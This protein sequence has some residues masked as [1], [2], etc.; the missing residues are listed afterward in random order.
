MKHW[1]KKRKGLA[2]AVALVLV[3]AIGAGLV[4]LAPGGGEVVGVYPFSRVGMTEYWGDS[5]ESY[6]PVSTD[7]IQTV[8]L[9]DTQ[10]VTEILVKAGDKVKKGDVLMT[11]D[12]T[13]SGLS[14]ERKRLEV[15]KQ[16][17]A[18]DIAQRELREIKIMEPMEIP[19]Y[20]Q[21]TVDPF[22]GEVRKEP[23]ELFR[24]EGNDGTTQEKAV[25]CWLR[26]DVDT[27]DI[28]LE[29]IRRKVWNNAGVC[30][31]DKLTED[32]EICT[33]PM[34][35]HDNVAA[36]CDICNVAVCEHG[37]IFKLCEICTPVICRHDEVEED[38]A[39]CN[40]ERCQ[41][42]NLKDQCN[43]CVP[44]CIHG[45]N[46]AVCFPKCAHGNDPDTCTTCHP[47]KCEHG[48]DPDTCKKCPCEHGVARK[49]C[50]T[51]NPPAETTK[52]EQKQKK[53]ESA[54]PADPAQS[55]EP[56]E[57]TAASVSA[58]P[59]YRVQLLGKPDKKPQ[60]VPENYDYYVVFKV[61]EGNYQLGATTTWQ[62]VHVS[63]KGTDFKLDFFDPAMEDYSIPEIEPDEPQ[64]TQPEFDM[65]SGY[66]FEQIVQL[67]KEKEKQIKKLEFDLKM[68]QTEYKI[69]QTEL[70]DGNVYA[71]IDGEVISV[72]TEEEAKQNRQPVLKVSGGG[73]FL[74]Q[75][76]VSELEKEKM[77]IGQEVTVNDWNS[78]Q[79]Y[80]GT[81]RSMGD[82]PDSNGYW[83]GM[84]N[85]NTTYYPF[86][87]FVDGTAD[88]Q[89]GSYVS[90]MYSGAGSEN[91][92]YLEN[93]FLR[94][95][96]GRSYVY[97]LGPGG[98]LERRDVVTGKSLW[99]S[100][101]EILSGLSETDLIAFPYGKHVKPGAP[102]E[103]RD[104][105]ELYS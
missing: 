48:K 49:D 58:A 14:L 11:F 71:D 3:A 39:L 98:K 65:G 53:S 93:P 72:L 36:E 84:G 38:C 99:G 79:T 22:L 37:R 85:P 9:T 46:C 64:P 5:Q 16:Q 61:T 35:K 68:V 50:T 28:L 21:T 92:I 45:E 43:I 10:T 44:T 90:L 95:E 15:E 18:L 57:D 102:A 94:T 77:E 88:L 33:P 7:N 100:Y 54:K 86:T 104:L 62:G 17:L 23:Y 78:G 103:E 41:H 69:M 81:I 40:A 34:C 4:F 82:F 87:V 66:T 59:G 101:T 32:C 26:E 56:R 51:C 19:Y 97:V 83:N 80:T 12:T 24:I 74:I 29:E 55:T 67:L 25:V 60:K 6:G 20:D 2:A 8:F 27:N 105:S 89:A 42:D 76:S 31:H 91:G 73:G 96:Q 75:G 13:L 1:N 70:E 63:G 47:P 52:T 30:Q